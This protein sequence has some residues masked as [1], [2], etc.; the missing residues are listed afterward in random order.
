[1]KFKEA[2]ILRIRLK[3]GSTLEQKPLTF[4]V[5]GHEDDIVTM[6]DLNSPE[7]GEFKLR[8]SWV[9]QLCNIEVLDKKNEE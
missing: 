6:I 3:T 9:E 4:F 7:E 5:T 1:M 2:M 8:H